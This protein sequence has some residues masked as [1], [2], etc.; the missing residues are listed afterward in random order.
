MSTEE[1]LITELDHNANAAG[2]RPLERRLADLSIWF[3]RRKQAIPFGNLE[4]RV[5]H[6]EKALWIQLEV[7]ALLLER[8]HEIEGTK[9]LWTA[10]GM[11]FNGVSFR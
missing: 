4:A 3:Y 11:N 1:T 6:L 10:S 8:L 9:R 7:N 5:S 2:N